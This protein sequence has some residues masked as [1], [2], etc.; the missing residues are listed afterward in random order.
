L[1]ALDGEDLAGRQEER[2]EHLPL[3]PSNG[4]IADAGSFLVEMRSPQDLIEGSL[5]TLKENEL[6]TWSSSGTHL[7]SFRVDSH[8]SSVLA[9]MLRL[10]AKKWITYSAYV[11]SCKRSMTEESVEGGEYDVDIGFTIHLSVK[12]T[13][14][15]MNNELGRDL[16]VLV[17][18]LDTR[19]PCRS[20]KEGGLAQELRSL[21]AFRGALSQLK[22]S[23]DS[24]KVSLA[25]IR[26]N[27]FVKDCCWDSLHDNGQNLA[28]LFRLGSV[29]LALNNLQHEDV[30]D[31]TNRNSTPSLM[32]QRKGCSKSVDLVDGAE[33]ELCM[34][35]SDVWKRVR[36][37]GVMKNP[38]GSFNFFADEGSVKQEHRM[39]DLKRVSGKS[40][41]RM[42]A[43]DKSNSK[44]QR[45]ALVSVRWKYSLGA[46]VRK[47][48]GEV[49]LCGK[50]VNILRVKR[51]QSLKYEVRY[52]SGEQE[53]VSFPHKCFECVEE[54][55]GCTFVRDAFVVGMEDQHV[56]V[57][58]ASTTL[59]ERLLLSEV[60][61][62][63]ESIQMPIHVLPDDVLVV[64]LDQLDPLEELSVA[65]M[66][67]RSLN[68]AV[69]NMIPGLKLTLYG[70]QRR[71]VAWMLRRETR[72]ERISNPSVEEFC[73][74]K[75]KDFY[76]NLCKGV[77]LSFEAEK[78]VEDVRGGFLCDE[79]GM[80]K[81]ITVL[82]LILKSR[83][84]RGWNFLNADESDRS[85]SESL[86]ISP[87]R[88]TRLSAQA[89]SPTKGVVKF[90]SR[91]T[92]IVVP[93][94]LLHHWTYQ[95]SAH[96]KRGT[97]RLHTVSKSSEILSAKDMSR[98]DVVLTTFDVLS[99]QWSLGS[100]V[101]G[102]HRWYQQ[103]RVQSLK[104]GRYVHDY[105][106]IA[107][108][109]RKVESAQ[110]ETR[111]GSEFLKVKWRRIILDEGH[112]M[113][114]T[115]ETNRAMMC[116]NIDAS[117]RWICTGTPTPNNPG[118][119]LMHLYGLMCFLR[120]KPFANFDVWRQQVVL[121]FESFDCSAW[122][123]LHAML[124][125]SM[126]RS[127]KADMERLG[128]IPACK[129]ETTHIRLSRGEQEAYNGLVSIIRRNLILAECDDIRIDS[130]LHS[131]NRKYA[132]EAISNMRKA[133]CVTGQFKIAI[134]KAHLDESVEVMRRGHSLQDKGC[135]CPG[136]YFDMNSSK[137]VDCSDRGGNCPLLA[138]TSCVVPERRIMNVQHAFVPES[139][140]AGR[141]SLV[142][143]HCCVCDKCNKSSIFPFISPCG[144]LICLN[145]VD[146]TAMR[147]CPICAR[148]FSLRS[149]A[150]FQPSVEQS[151][152]TW[153]PSWIDDL[154]SKVALLLVR[155]RHFGFLQVHKSQEIW[156]HNKVLRLAKQTRKHE[157]KSPPQRHPAGKCIVYSNFIET[158]DNVANSIS[159][160]MGGGGNYMRF[161]ANLKRGM[162]ERNDAIQQFR[163][164]PDIQIILIDSAG[165]LGLDLSFV[166]HVYLLD[167][168]WDKSQEDQVI[169]RAHRL[170]AKSS[171]T[172]EKFIATGTVE[173]IME[174][175]M[176][177]KTLSNASKSGEKH[178]ETG[179][180][181]VRN[182]EQRKATEDKK[183]RWILTNV[184][185]LPEDQ[186][187]S[188]EASLEAAAM[189]A[190][191]IFATE[192]AEEAEMNEA[193]E[194]EEVLSDLESEGEEE[195]LSRRDFI[196]ADA[197]SSRPGYVFRPGELGL[198]YYR[199][200][201]EA[202]PAGSDGE[203][204]SRGGKRVRF[205]E[206]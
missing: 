31:E 203:S 152:M 4:Y 18:H 178:E 200:L 127:L 150:D 170:G 65:A 73:S 64:L 195:A 111:N 10:V 63:R 130:L 177:E 62:V 140:S 97:L 55:R 80:G 28:P 87:G 141:T 92:L 30:L 146:A 8:H 157:S 6:T 94:T 201:V 81:T 44:P 126:F 116:S 85:S 2:Q 180:K 132:L 113:G 93:G 69:Q 164:N 110:E 12:L 41:Y 199:D 184:K 68:N 160:A 106:G 7:S 101:L 109:K 143:Q 188:M 179:R 43:T 27:C 153:N 172:V 42:A 14:D 49:V 139:F 134:V 171:I 67:C 102:S 72:P 25:Q 24:V 176:K 131:K 53:V 33:L 59:V 142:D 51:S 198:G 121:P 3:N 115:N 138:D 58:Y 119:E 190:R 148:S 39:V 47:L 26:C 1:R 202:G 174:L 145:C 154:S 17:M 74:K 112:V 70:H 187:S 91:A 20:S 57:R 21:E 32:V 173:E 133:C 124:S 156:W 52:E 194:E 166:T 129:V 37:E 136:E 135:D 48:A 23:D 193:V 158:I 15:S 71:A 103:Q 82:A 75:G 35:E 155:L 165:A 95:I 120:S 83:S 76:I 182:E 38:D 169:S 149:F 98:L 54:S 175:W 90:P 78:E 159:E 45:G 77:S 123:R 168:I 147:V 60:L 100:P 185:L 89:L 40:S 96:T 105:V 186:D 86:G 183:I 189:S 181:R 84:M 151:N 22:E 19:C 50:I 13:Y 117:C 122:V 114:G 196:P 128:E 191:H 34:Y 56:L 88:L 9:A 161:T 5:V 144:H 16:H 162:L 79:P 167:P 104:Q 36:V 46:R 61:G 29:L 204:S 192:D 108:F 205:A 197:G 99:K 163:D 125:R 66:T 118:S 206:M 137:M 107:D 11:N